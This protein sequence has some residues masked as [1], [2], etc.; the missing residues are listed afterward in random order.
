MNGLPRDLAS[1]PA[2]EI[3]PEEPDATVAYTAFRRDGS[4]GTVAAWPRGVSVTAA[5]LD[6]Y[7]R[8]ELVELD[9]RGATAGKEFLAAVEAWGRVADHDHVAPV[10]GSG[11]RPR[12]WVATAGDRTLADRGRGNLAPTLWIGV[13]LAGALACAHDAGVVHGAITPDRVRLRPAPDWSFP[14][15]D[16]FSLAGVLGGGDGATARAAPEQVAPEPYHGT[17]TVTDVYGLALTLYEA[18]TGDL[19]YVTDGDPRAAVLGTEPVPPSTVEPTLP[20]AVDDVLLP[21]LAKDPAD[22]PALDSFRDDVVSLLAAEIPDD[23]SGGGT[24]DPDVAPFPFLDGDRADWRTACPSCGRSVT[25]TLAAFRAHW[26]DADRCDGP[27]ERP[28]VRADH[29]REEWARVVESVESASGGAGGGTAP[30]G[31]TGGSGGSGAVDHPLWTALAEGRVVEVG[32]VSVASADGTYPWLHCP[33]RGWR[34]PCP[35][36]GSTVFN[37]ETAMKAHWSAAP[38]CPGPPDDFET[39]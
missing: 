22:R 1:A 8:V 13:C 30:A 32:G 18:L 35:A 36:C 39:A 10:V 31:G 38:G 16:G 2:P 33:R 17:G 19:P 28:P 20:A 29:S 6:G 27:P 12:P 26:R 5:R 23:G 4:A 7:G 37:T 11:K 25:N 3:L 24:A 21:A 9:G 34:V 14:R 15:L